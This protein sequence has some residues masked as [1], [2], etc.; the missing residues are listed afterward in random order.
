[1]ESMLKNIG[2]LDEVAAAFREAAEAFGE[3][4]ARAEVGKAWEQPSAMEGYSVGAVVTHVNGAIGWLGQLLDAPPEPDLRPTPPADYL[5]FAHALKIGSDGTD[6]HPLHDVLHAQFER[7]A[8]RGWE[9]N[10]DKFLG[11]V[12]RLTVRLEGESAARLLDLRP[13][14]PL[15]VRLGDLLR[16]RVVELVV[17]GDDLAV[18]VGLDAPPP[19][20]AAAAVAIDFLLAVARAAHGDLAVVRALARRE[21]A[22]AAV[23]PIL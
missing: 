16:S 14:V 10:R 9:P 13:T 18:S 19:P 12:E 4:V 21:R 22:D 7:A 20:E 8:T 17:H 5:R 3:I 1:M 2:G 11:L 23:F 6:R 15:V